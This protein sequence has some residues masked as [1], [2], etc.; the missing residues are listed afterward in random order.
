MGNDFNSDNQSALNLGYNRSPDSVMQRFVSSYG[1]RSTVLE[2]FS[3]REVTKAQ[4]LNR[5]F[6]DLWIARVQTR[7]G[8]LELPFL[9]TG[10]I[11]DGT[12]YFGFF[13]MVANQLVR[14]HCLNREVNS[15]IQIRL[16]LFVYDNDGKWIQFTDLER[17]TITE[18]ALAA[19]MFP[20]VEDC[21]LANFDD[22]LIF[23]IGG[24]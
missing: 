6:Y 16:S 11:Q 23:L 18:K 5:E 7:I 2:F 10:D 4:I 12:N 24:S 3:L 20:L 15:C 21:S 9:F 14:K 8:K 17:E 13:D 1:V 19:P 22:E